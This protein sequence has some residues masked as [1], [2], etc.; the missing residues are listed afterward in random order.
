MARFLGDARLVILGVVLWLAGCALTPQEQAIQNDIAAATPVV[1][2]VVDAGL[3]ATGNAA[4]VPLNDLAVQGLEAA[5]RAQ[6]VGAVNPAGVG[7]V[8]AH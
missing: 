6:A 3:I 1:N 4:V 5:Q 8:S 7:S 2:K